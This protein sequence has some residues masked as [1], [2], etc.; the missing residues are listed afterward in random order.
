[1]SLQGPNLQGMSLSEDDQVL[2]AD[3]AM[4]LLD[5]A[6]EARADDRVASDPEFAAAVEA[7]RA[8]FADFDASAETA[9][10]SPA[11]WTRITETI[12]PDTVIPLPG[13]RAAVRGASCGKALR[14][15]G[16]PASAACS[17]R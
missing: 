8:R 15:G 3:Y 7:W 12:K 11:L 9:A 5:D 10:P 1:M 2:A 6:E 14:S 13:A 4:G 17:R 16:W